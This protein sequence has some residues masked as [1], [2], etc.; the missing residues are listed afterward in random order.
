MVSVRLPIKIFSQFVDKISV[1]LQ[2]NTTNADVNMDEAIDKFD[3][4]VS[5]DEM[6]QI[7]S[8]AAGLSIGVMVLMML[9]VGLFVWALM[10]IVKNWTRLQHDGNKGV[11]FLLLALF[12]PTIGPVI[13][14]I[15]V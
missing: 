11:L 9:S 13:T 5:A 4:A 1:L 8:D 10:K 6:D 2:I 14:V 3:S 7:K 12:V 15:S